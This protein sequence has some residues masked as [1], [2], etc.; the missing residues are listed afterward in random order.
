MVAHRKLAGADNLYTALAANR[1]PK[2]ADADNL[3]TARAANQQPPQ[4]L[5]GLGVRQIGCAQPLQRAKKSG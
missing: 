2:L 3:L 4:G 1:Q 5:W